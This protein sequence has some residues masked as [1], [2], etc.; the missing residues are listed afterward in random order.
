[1]LY[2]AQIENNPTMLVE[3][4]KNKYNE[5]ILVVGANIFCGGEES[6]ESFQI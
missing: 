3:V 5:I 4:F 6:T 1:M 2:N